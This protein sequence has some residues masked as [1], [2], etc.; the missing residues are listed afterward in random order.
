MT[1]TPQQLG[2]FVDQVR[3]DRFF[4]LWM[5]I[6][7]TGIP[8]KRLLDLRRQDV[9]LQETRL[10]TSPADAEKHREMPFGIARSYALDP[11]A[12]E[13]LREHVIAWDKDVSGDD[14]RSK[15]LFVWADEAPLHPKS[16]EVLFHRHCQKAGLPVVPFQTMR[17]AYVV[18]AIETG[19]PTAVISERLGRTIAPTSTNQIR[20][21]DPPLDPARRAADVRRTAVAPTRKPRDPDRRRSCHL[22]SC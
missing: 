22:R 14:Q 8:I 12:H 2:D 15:R 3:N 9:D 11:D 19:I 1:W 21:V 5:L 10:S 13:A 6:A 17:Q 20:Q 16:V 7:T 4:A 18:A